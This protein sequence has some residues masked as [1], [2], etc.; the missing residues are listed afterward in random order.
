MTDAIA[1]FGTLVQAGAALGACLVRLVSLQA[2]NRYTARRVEFADDGTTQFADDE[3]LTVTN[4]AEPAD[5]AGQL[6]AD[7]EAVAIDAEGRWV[8]F[9]RLGG[10]GNGGATAQFPAKILS[11]QGG[12]LYTVREQALSPAGVF[13]DAP[14]ATDVTA[15]NLAEL[16]L[17][18]GAAVPND[19]IILAT[20]IEDTGNPPTL[21]YVFD[22]PAYAKYLT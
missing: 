9:I 14:G 7:T 11:A 19:A 17:G 20:A 15:R 5:T 22:H 10:E 18:P 13:S 1:H 21:R 8:I 3:T 6:T 4:L 12:G 2:A 16:A